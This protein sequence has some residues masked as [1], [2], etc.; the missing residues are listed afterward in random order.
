M[1]ATS[2]EV[3]FAIGVEKALWVSVNNFGG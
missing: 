2:F 3:K 1:F